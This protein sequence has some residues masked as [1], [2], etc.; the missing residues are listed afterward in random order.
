M[1][2]S[3]DYIRII[4]EISDK[5]NLPLIKEI[6]TPQS[7][8]GGLENSNFSVIVLEDTTIGLV[9]INLNPR[10]K[11]TFENTDFSKYIGINPTAIGKLFNSNDMFE[12]SLALGSINAIS[13]FIFKKANF[14]FDFT[15]DSL[16]QL[17]IKRS[18]TIGMVGLFSP[19]VKLIEK[20]GAELIIIEKKED[21]VEETENWIVT[22]NPSE[23]EKCNKV[24]ITGTT[25]LNETL[26]EV[27]SYCTNAKKKTIIGP[28]ASILPDPLFERGID[29]I[30]GTYVMNPENLAHAI[31]KNIRWKNSVKKY[32]I[33]KENYLGY[34]DLL[35]KFRK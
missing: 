30:G 18:D 33:E 24:L 28:T 10:V 34:K 26:D 32:T 23:L 5:V 31:K 35:S 9:Y 7:N 13:Q 15:T 16:G 8:E 14:S 3:S 2:I 19:L 20:I 6:L 21:L 22:L 25:I 29:V 11:Q 12:K 4:E 1:A 17:N 27:L